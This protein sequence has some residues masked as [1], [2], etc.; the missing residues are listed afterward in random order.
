MI[1][2]P[3]T[4]AGVGTGSAQHAEP[5][6]RALPHGGKTSIASEW[7]R[8]RAIRLVTRSRTQNIRQE[9][10]YILTTTLDE[11]PLYEARVTVHAVA[12]LE[13]VRRNVA[14]LPKAGGSSRTEYPDG[15]VIVERVKW[16]ELAER[17]H[18]APAR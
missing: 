16:A 3:R 6:G 18:R 5:P 11:Q 10:T 12:T 14:D 13:D 8:H 2:A 1:V 17:V 7:R 9:M 15:T 4:E